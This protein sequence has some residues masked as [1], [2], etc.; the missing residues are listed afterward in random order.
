MT[1]TPFIYFFEGIPE[2]L[3]DVSLRRNR[4]TGVRSVLLTFKQLKSIER[5]N[6]YT[7]RFAQGLRL[8]D[9]E[10]EISVEPDSV[11]FVFG[12]PEGDELVRV[13]C[14]FEIQ[15]EDHWERFVRFMNRYAEANGMEYGERKQT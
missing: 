3:S 8:V 13:E 6:S 11:Q 15:R 10:G 14:K 9:S 12:G 1:S 7:K 4:S 2:E 5:F